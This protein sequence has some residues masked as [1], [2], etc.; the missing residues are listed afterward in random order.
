MKWARRAGA[1][2]AVLAVVS[3]APSAL[4][5]VR[6]VT[7]VGIPVW[8]RSPCITMQMDLTNPPPVLSPDEFANA[9]VLA[10]RAWSHDAIACSSVS[11]SLDKVLSGTLEVG[12]DGKNVILFHR[13]R[14]CRLSASDDPEGLTCHASNVLALTTLT[15]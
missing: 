14:W 9:A 5:Y 7:S 13:D 2:T 1:L 11:L 3:F 6:A 10:A 12:R 8:W 4:A 15:Q